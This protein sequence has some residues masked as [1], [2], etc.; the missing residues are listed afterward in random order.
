MKSRK[1][2]Y[3][4]PQIKEKKIKLNHFYRRSSGLIENLLT[5]FNCAAP[6]PAGCPAPC[7]ECWGGGWVY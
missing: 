6:G 2:L 1:L 3:K 7:N 5:E 4:K